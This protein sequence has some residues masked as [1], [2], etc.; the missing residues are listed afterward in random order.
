MTTYADRQTN[1]GLVV[2][3][4]F[5]G[6][7]D[8]CCLVQRGAVV[9]LANSRVT[10][11]N[12]TKTVHNVE[13]FILFNIL[14]SELW[15]Y[16]LFWNVSATKEIGRFFDLIGCHGKTAWQ[17]RKYSTDPS[18][19]RK[20]LS[21][22][23]KIVNICP[24]HP[25]IFD[26]I[27][28]TTT[29][30]GNAISIRIFSS[31]TTGPIFTKF[32][33][34]VVTLVVLLNLAHI[35]RYPISFLNDRAIS[36]GDRQFCPIFAQNRLPWQ[37]PLRYQKLGT[38]RSSTPKMLSFDVK[39]AKIGPAYLQI[40]CLREIIKKFLKKIEITESKIYSPSSKFAERAK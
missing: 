4:I 1:I 26:K 18:S 22:G 30:T 19:A 9:T 35:R 6:Y 37:R 7:G 15:Y 25:E 29:W 28:Q 36:A 40:I 3:E 17:I 21:Y 38:D 39:I 16:D 23:E 24:A 27:R 12:V 5:G 11:P 8:F 2:T 14:K 10:G 33:Y 34:N 31:E 20:E 32:L 13:K